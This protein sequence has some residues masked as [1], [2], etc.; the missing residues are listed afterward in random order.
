[1]FRSKVL[2]ALLSVLVILAATFLVI[3]SLPSRYV[4]IRSYTDDAGGLSE[5]TSV[6][7]N[8]I[9]IGELERVSLTTSRDPHRKI[10]LLMRVRRRSLPDIPSDSRV[11][12]A[13]SNLLG[14]YF[15]DIMRGRASQP[16]QAG[17]ELQS[18]E[19]ADP[20][21]L[22][23]EM[24]N[25]LQEIQ[26]IFDRADKLITSTVD[27]GQGNIAKWQNGGTREFDRISAEFQKLSDDINTGQG[28]LSKVNEV[29]AEMSG[30]QKRLNDVVAAYQAPGGAAAR[31]QALTSNLKAMSDESGK[32]MASVNA[33]GGPLKR[34]SQ[35]GDQF[36]QVV[37]RLQS[38]ADR[39]N[40]GQGTLGQLV[41]NPQFS[42][43]LA[44]TQKQ[45]QGL[46]NDLKTNPKK[47]LHFRLALF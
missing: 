34:L 19:P 8:G 37:Q 36:D 22:L 2:I 14:N 45:F 35:V 13:A 6:R 10:E 39:V 40:S 32:L 7:L 26:G 47:F 5:G 9:P 4:L 21:K 15:I 25:E 31:I 46:A 29:S 1:M 12:V 3:R 43:A 17:G 18:A 23:A 44:G 42:A 30:E 11:G 38:S 24:G 33:E 41:V 20:S 27:A 16:V 28:N